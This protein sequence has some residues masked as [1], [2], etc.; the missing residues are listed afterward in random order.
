[1]DMNRAPRWSLAL[2]LGAVGLL[3]SAAPLPQTPVYTEYSPVAQDMADRAAMLRDQGRLAEAARLYQQII[4]EYGR[5]LMPT[6]DGLRIDAGLWVQRRM[7]GDQELL[8]AY[9]D[10][11]EIACQ[12]ALALVTDPLNNPDALE[13]IVARYALCES[14]MEAALRL[15]G[16]YLEQADASNA[17]TVLDDLQAH[18]DFDRYARRCHELWATAA[19]I[20]NDAD[21]FE[22]QSLALRALGANRMADRLMAQAATLRHPEPHSATSELATPPEIALP[23]K[24]DEPLWQTAFREQPPPQPVVRHTRHRNQTAGL[25]FAG[26]LPFYRPLPVTDG[27][28]LFLN[29]TDNI[30][31]FDPISGRLLWS[32]AG[33]DSDDNTQA[34]QLARRGQAVAA[35]HRAVLIRGNR[36]V[37]V[38]GHGIGYFTGRRNERSLTS[39]VCLDRDTG[40]PLWRVEPGELDDTLTRADFVGTP[41]QTQGMVYTVASRMQVAGFHD[42]YIVAID[43]RNGEMRWRRHLSS[44]AADHQAQPRQIALIVD[45]GRLFACD[46]RSTVACLDGRNGS[47]RWMKVQPTGPREPQEFDQRAAR[48]RQTPQPGR[49]PALVMTG[50]G[51]LLLTSAGSD[52]TGLLLDAESGSELRRFDG[53]Y[54]SDT[55]YLLPTE[56]GVITVGRT[57]QYLRGP[58]LTA[59]WTRTLG[60]TQNVDPFGRGAVTG[61]RVLI[62]TRTRLIVLDLADGSVVDSHRLSRP[63]NIAPLP[64]QLI[65]IDNHSVRS[66]LAW[67]RAYEHLTRQIAHDPLDPGPALALAHVSMA[68]GRPKAVLEGVDQ[69]LE[70]LTL[71]VEID[72]PDNPEATAEHGSLR[73]QVFD[74]VLRLVHP[75]RTDD[76]KLRR[77][78]FDRLAKATTGPANEVAYQFELG[79]FL[80][81]AGK[82]AEAVERYQAVLLDR[83]LSAELYTYADGS[84]QAATEATHRLTEL[85][86][87]HGRQI[88]Q[89]YDTQAAQRLVELGSVPGADLA[90]LR[91]LARQFPVSR[92]APAAMIAAAEA[93]ADHGQ[94]FAAIRQLERAYRNTG[95]AASLQRI[96]GR[97]VELNLQADRT[98]HARNWLTRLR[99]DHPGLRPLRDGRPES[100]TRWLADLAADPNRV[101]SLSSIRLPIH[102]AVIFPGQAMVPTEQPRE[103]WPTDL[104]V[105]QGSDAISLRSGPALLERWRV[106][107]PN[108]HAQLLSLTPEQALFWIDPNRAHQ[109]AQPRSRRGQPPARPTIE[110]GYLL[111][112]DTRTGQPLWPT[113]ELAE[114]LHTVTG[115]GADG[116]GVPAALRQPEM[117][118]PAVRAR[119]AT[120]ALANRLL[121]SE[122]A[123]GIVDNAGRIVMVDRHTGQVLW[124]RRTG[125]DQARLPQISSTIVALTGMRQSLATTRQWEIHAYD[126]STGRPLLT[127]AQ[128]QD[129]IRWIGLSHEDKIFYTTSN[130]L[131]GI[132]IDSADPPWRIDLPGHRHGGHGWIGPKTLLLQMLGSNKPLVLIDHRSGTPISRVAATIAQPHHPPAVQWIGE[133]A[134]LQSDTSLISVSPGGDV[135]WT[136]AISGVANSNTRTCLTGESVVAV[137]EQIA[138]GREPT[139]TLPKLAALPLDAQAPQVPAHRVTSKNGYWYALRLLDRHSG[140][141][142]AEHLIGPLPEPLLP[143]HGMIVDQSLILSMGRSTLVLHGPSHMQ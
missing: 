132:A 80:V 59:A 121:V 90:S 109:H 6:G 94:L 58:G 52:S 97:L 67:A 63:G 106:P 76:L 3:V 122:T 68:A 40:Q 123:A 17:L 13:A 99:S 24:L 49:G 8:T 112:L 35:D 20:L 66:Y 30:V 2:C 86:E 62:P 84:V 89:R 108:G 96:V 143:R 12:R 19:M 103:D 107:R 74:Q 15:T 126:A 140:V 56:N 61:D 134:Y 22:D 5:R 124:G 117:I 10:Q 44:V 119:V 75:E 114:L 38:V 133:H 101:I 69:A 16:V 28:R 65:V 73:Q 120:A 27:D 43:P 45:R 88:Y 54:W 53:P 128:G 104:L 31:A 14:G 131:S 111:A 139:Q 71:R 11:H 7:R 23:S 33:S 29:I 39:L 100:V 79:A 46:N 137:V 55:A 87:E 18:P 36:I 118:D 72:K 32:Y 21:A 42:V 95:E 77:K 116:P 64:D 102:R 136:D 25:S 50:A 92:S 9:R 26:S 81:E 113:V 37:A 105:L 41:V 91:A 82:P 78:L 93:L 115:K 141:L 142:I 57:V 127:T 48:A 4:E 83:Q 110:P 60:E 51:L 135:L 98:R 1:M 129:I 70:A 34:Q 130:A 138:S 47:V 85:I 125:L